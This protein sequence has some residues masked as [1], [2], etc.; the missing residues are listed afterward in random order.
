MPISHFIALTYY[1]II[2]SIIFCYE[3][4]LQ[5]KLFI[6]KD[7]LAVDD[8]LIIRLQ[9]MNIFEEIII[10]SEIDERNRLFA[11]LE[12]NHNRPDFDKYLLTK[13]QKLF[14]QIAPNAKVYIF[15][16][17]QLY[18]YFIFKQNYELFIIEDSYKSLEQ[19]QQTQRFRNRYKLI[20]PH[21]GTSFPKNDFSSDKIVKI[22]SSTPYNNGKNW[23]DKII[24]W[25]YKEYLLKHKINLQAQLNFLFQY[26]NLNIKKGGLILT[27]PLSRY[28]YCNKVEQLRVYKKMKQELLASEIT[29]ENINIKPHPADKLSYRSLVNKT[30]NIMKKHF[31]IDLIVMEKNE[32]SKVITYGS[33]AINYFDSNSIEKKSID[34]L[35]NKNE[36]K[37]SK[38][39]KNYIRNTKLT[40]AVFDYYNTNV[41]SKNKLVFNK[42]SQTSNLIWEH[43][44]YKNEVEIQ[45]YIRKNDIDY[46]I[47]NDLNII[48]CPKIMKKINR[49]F[50]EV[51][52]AIQFFSLNITKNNRTYKF[53]CT[54]LNGIFIGPLGNKIISRAIILEYYNLPNWEKREHYLL[55]LSAL[56]YYSTYIWLEIE[57]TCFESVLKIDKLTK[58]KNKVV[59]NKHKIDYFILCMLSI[60]QAINELLYPKNHEQKYIDYLKQIEQSSNIEL[61]KLLTTNYFKIKPNRLNLKKYGRNRILQLFFHVI[62]SW[63]I[64]VQEFID[65][66]CQ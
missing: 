53:N 51:V 41:A 28:G 17:Y 25:D 44:Q 20:I 54:L 36:K 61:T 6:L 31:P 19:Q 27:Q 1:H 14:R 48:F 47:I 24:I 38:D 39:I 66:L 18:A 4:K 33:T 40:I 32:F 5:A 21:I 34:T 46:V 8:E 29:L 60:R 35:K 13:Y 12:N 26:Q 57:Y 49:R 64:E 2:Y 56:S 55:N 43:Q 37:I 23:N 45:E 30:S 62:K 59:N 10:F 15:N 3:H 65:R 7:Y 16:T 22:I 11:H 50:T 52:G 9:K 42:K 63:V 58:L